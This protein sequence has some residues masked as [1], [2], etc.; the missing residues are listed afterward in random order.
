MPYEDVEDYA[1]LYDIVYQTT[2]DGEDIDFYVEQARQADGRV[3]EV[4]CGTGRIYLDLLDVG[5]D[6][7]GID[8]SVEMLEKLRSKAR[9]RGLE[10]D[11]YEADMRDFD[12]EKTFSLIIIPYRSFLHNLTVKD[13]LSVLE[14]IYN[15]LEPGGKLILNFFCPDI[16]YISE[17]FG[18]ESRTE[19]RG[20]EYTLVE[21]TELVDSVNWIIEFEKKLLKNGNEK[22][23]SKAKTKMT[24]KNEFELLLRNSSFEEWSVYGGFDLGKLKDSKQEMIWIVEK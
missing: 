16:D 20:G 18:E 1:E 22:W 4:A 21:Q 8:L 2:N 15:H 17:N 12:L 19:I 5:I 24:T 10:T 23:S 14:N 7:S 3:L 6:A 13:Q 11:V 9:D